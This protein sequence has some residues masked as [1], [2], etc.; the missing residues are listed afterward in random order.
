MVYQKYGLR[1]LGIGN[2]ENCICRLQKNWI[3]KYILCLISATPDYPYTH[4]GISRKS[5]YLWQNIYQ[6]T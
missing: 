3:T 1:E 4:K 2:V 5:G 6:L